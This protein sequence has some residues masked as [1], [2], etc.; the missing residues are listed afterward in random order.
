MKLIKV[1]FVIVCFSLLSLAANAQASV[2]IGIKGGLNFA[3]VNAT[4]SAGTTYNNRTGY[5]FGAYTLFKLG[6]IGIQPEVLFSKQGTKYSYSTSN[7]DANFDYVNIPVI[8]KLY[9]VA[10]INLQVGPQIGFLSGG[11][12]KSTTSGVTTTQGAANFV[13]GSDIS[14]ALGA[15]WDLPFGLSIDARYNLGVSNNN[16]VSGSSSN[17][18]NQVIMVSAGYRLFKLGK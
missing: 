16:N 13:K 7:V 3:N 8:L 6:K 1:S 15:G 17:V 12:I 5:H 10:G 18:K 4:Q 14:V 2:G 9:T 11:D